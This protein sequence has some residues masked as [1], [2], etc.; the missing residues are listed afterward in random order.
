MERLWKEENQPRSQA[1]SMANFLLLNILNKIA[2]II[3]KEPPHGY[4]ICPIWVLG[5]VKEADQNE[6]ANSYF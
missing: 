1:K 4:I 5:L 6:K 3:L 2:I